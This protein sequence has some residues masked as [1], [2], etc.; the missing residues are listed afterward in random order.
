MCTC[1]SFL[2][3]FYRPETNMQ[4][5]HRHRLHYCKSWPCKVQFSFFCL[6]LTQVQCYNI[7][8]MEMARSHFSVWGHGKQGRCHNLSKI[9][10][11][12]IGDRSWHRGLC[13]VTESFETIKRPAVENEALPGSPT[14]KHTTTVGKVG[15]FLLN[16]KPF[17]L[18][19]LLCRPA[20]PV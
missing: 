1:S 15:G 9:V 14:A 13:G 4:L 10:H 17:V 7:W 3:F 2:L 18:L 20:N 19:D 16:F 8:Y 5:E 12:W 11:S 6:N